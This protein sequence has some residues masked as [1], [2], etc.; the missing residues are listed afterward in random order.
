[1][2]PRP[3][4][5]FSAN[6]FYF[7]LRKGLRPMMFHFRPWLLVSILCVPAI[8]ISANS[9]ALADKKIVQPTQQQIAAD[10]SKPLTLE[11]AIKIGLQNQNT[12]GIAK[13]QVDSSKARITESKSSYYPQIA[14][15]FQYSSQLTTLNT[16]TGRQ[17]GVFEQ[18]TTRIGLQQLIFDMGKREE[19]VL[20]AKYGAKSS[21]FN[22]LDARQIVIVNVATAYYELLRRIE[23]V[24]VADS[25]VDRAKTTLDSTRESARV[26]AIAA[27]DVFQAEADYDNAKVQQ[28]IARND[29]R[30]AATSLKTAMG[31][32]TQ[33][34]IT[35][36]T[37]PLPTPSETPDTK[38]AVDYLN[39]ALERRS[40]LRSQ[41]AA[42]DSNRHNVKIANINAGVTVTSTVTEGYRIDPNPGE[43]RDFVT[44]FSYPLFDAG[45]TRAAVRIAKSTLDQAKFQLE[46][47][48]Q[49]IQQDVENQY[50]LREEARARIGAANAAVKAAKINYDAA[51]AARQEGAGTIIEVITAQNA[52]VTAETNAVQAIFDFYSAD[53]RLRR[54]TGENDPYINAGR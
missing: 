4:D 22:L 36:P 39:T 31:V 52:L 35:T 38:Q 30:L 47:T 19:N 53:A 51:T 41:Q 24:K 54:A 1:M 42:I 37:D 2:K 26:G 28:I 32:L 44:S 29:V 23:L 33:V 43:D 34:P 8:G 45:A 16:P 49:A 46:L 3:S 50:V 48:K 9:S 12:L 17:T 13:A 20:V 10:L 21:E 15:T 27:K 40:D 6:R 18:S 14:P 7:M 5:C 25:S 11:N